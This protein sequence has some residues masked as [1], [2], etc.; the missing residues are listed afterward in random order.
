[1]DPDPYRPEIVLLMDP[2]TGLVVNVNAFK[3]S[4]SAEEF[5]GWIADQ[6]AG[7]Q[8]HTEHRRLRT[9]DH[10][11]APLLREKLA[12]NWDVVV[13]PT[14]EADEALASLAASLSA[15]PGAGG[16]FADGATPE[17]VGRFFAAAAPVFRAAPWR[18]ATDAQVLA[19]NAPRFGYEGA[20]LSIIGALGESFG[21][22]VYASMEDYLSVVRIA[23][24]GAPVEG[25]GVPTFAVNFDQAT[26]VPRRLRQEAKRHGWPV[27]RGGFPTISRIDPDAVLRPLGDRDYAF[28]AVLLAA[29]LRFLGEQGRIF[30][31]HELPQ[32]VQARYEDETGSGVVL[33]AP[34][35]RATWPWGGSADAAALATVR[36]GAAD[37]V[38]ADPVASSWRPKLSPRSE[39]GS[40]SVS[41]T[42]PSMGRRRAP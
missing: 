32:A 42:V 31:A 25:P 17:A 26:E 16:H 34:H 2:V 11:L 14:P 29:L 18:A 30:A 7:L 40:R 28:A 36:A 41:K 24:R 8:R 5:A 12:G 13:G 33:T 21:L 4:E 9:N 38:G 37:P 1:M 10:E 23:I 19:V 6:A 3:P 22:V 35:P 27:Q 15:P 39:A 20:S